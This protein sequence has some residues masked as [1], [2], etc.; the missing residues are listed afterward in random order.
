MKSHRLRNSILVIIL[1]IIVFSIAVLLGAFRSSSIAP[2][3]KQPLSADDM[4]LL[5]SKGRELV[6][7]G[8]CMGCHSQAQGPQGAGGVAI[9]TPFGTIYSTNITPDKEHGIGNYSR[10]DLHRVL[11]DGIAPGDRNL[12]PAKIGRASCREREKIPLRRAAGE[13]QRCAV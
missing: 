3:A 6:F 4:E 12:Y 1:L 5:V 7:A 2:Q 13:E 11:R 9:D 8:D 10:A